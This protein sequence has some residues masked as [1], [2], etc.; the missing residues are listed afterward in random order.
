MFKTM[1]GEREQGVLRGLRGPEAT[2]MTMQLEL[3][4]ELS[5]EEEEEGVRQGWR[6]DVASGPCHR[7]E[8]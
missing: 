1:E 5:G 8:K 6:V 2:T 7:F 3:E 4:L